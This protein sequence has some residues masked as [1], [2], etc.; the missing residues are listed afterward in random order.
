MTSHLVRRLRRLVHG[1]PTFVSLIFAFA[2]ANCESTSFAPPPV[3][4]QM[5][6]T[7]GPRINLAMLQTGRSLFASRCIE[8]HTLPALSRYDPVAWPW[9]VD[10]MAARASLKP[11]EREALL[12]YILA[13]RAQL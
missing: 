13:A 10:D 2:L 3:T 8:C 7:G 12:A 9:L 6:A 11:A 5:A 4:P 1:V